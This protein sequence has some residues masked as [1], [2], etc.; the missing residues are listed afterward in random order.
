MSASRGGVPMICIGP[1]FCHIKAGRSEGSSPRRY[2]RLRHRLPPRHSQ[3]FEPSFPSPPGSTRAGEG[4]GG[5]FSLGNP[6]PPG[7]GGC[8]LSS[9]TR[10][11]ALLF[12]RAKKIIQ[13]QLKVIWADPK[14][15]IFKRFEGQVMNS[16]RRMGEPG[17]SAAH[18]RVQSHRITPSI[19]HPSSHLLLPECRRGNPCEADRGL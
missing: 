7:G 5:L 13:G 10:T 1:R 16:W 15:G 8:R 19:L 12:V 17:G 4:F 18:P 14:G 11:A 6:R 9:P 2:S 3:L